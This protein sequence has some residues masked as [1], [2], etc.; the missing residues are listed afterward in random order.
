MR[1]LPFWIQRADFSFTEYD[2]VDHTEAVRI[3]Q[4]HDWV[5]ELVFR[6]E[7]ESRGVGFCDP[8]VAF[9]GEI[10]ETLHICFASESRAYFLYHFVQ[11]EKVFGLI[12]VRRFV[13]RSNIDLLWSEIPNVIYHYFANNHDWLVSRTEG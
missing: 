6:S 7:L 3:V 10:G 4:N 5:G 13:T 2:A 11:R 1:S 8:G 9:L 12:P